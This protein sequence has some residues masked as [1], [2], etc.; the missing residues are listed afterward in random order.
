MARWSE[1]EK[2]GGET[3][4]GVEEMNGEKKGENVTQVNTLSKLLFL[5]I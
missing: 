5:C 3:Q 4:G 1:G 2:G